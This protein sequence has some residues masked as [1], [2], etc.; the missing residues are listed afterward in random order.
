MQNVS[1]G[2]PGMPP[3]FEGVSFSVAPGERVQLAAPSG[4]G[5]TTLG[6]VI[7]GYERPATGRI[8]VDGEPLPMRGV[9]PIIELPTVCQGT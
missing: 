9:C 4:A 1:F 6:R 5:K 2:Y 3:L 7:A 8:L